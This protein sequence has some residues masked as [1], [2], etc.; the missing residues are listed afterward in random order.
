M[1]RFTGKTALV[2]GGNSGIGFVTAKLLIAEGA[3]VA[4]TGRDR[5]KLDQ[6][7]TELGGNALGVQANLDDEE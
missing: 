1:M 3:R 4:I 2:T 6:A 5:A 7:V